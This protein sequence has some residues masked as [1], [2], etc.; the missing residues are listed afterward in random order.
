MLNAEKFNY[1]QFSAVITQTL[2]KL[3]PSATQAL[4]TSS[5]PKKVF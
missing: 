5:V 3:A 1:K 4:N 2:Q